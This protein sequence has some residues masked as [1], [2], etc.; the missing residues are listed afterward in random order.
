MTFATRHQGCAA[1]IRYAVGDEGH[2]STRIN[3]QNRAVFEFDDSTGRATDL[4]QTFFGAEP[5]AIGDVRALLDV[6]KALRATVSEA[7]ANGGEWRN[8]RGQ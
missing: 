5:V 4:S 7:V 6:S 1:F 3:S 8:Q 2:R